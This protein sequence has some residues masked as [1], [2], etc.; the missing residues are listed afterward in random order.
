MRKSLLLLAFMMILIISGCRQTYFG[1]YTYRDFDH[2][3]HWNELTDLGH[4]RI[5]FVYYYDRDFFGTA[6]AGCKIVNESIFKFG[7]ENTLNAHLTLVNEREVQGSRPIGLR[8]APRL[9]IVESGQVTHNVLG[10]GPI[11]EWLEAIENEAFELP[12]YEPPHV[13]VYSDFEI[14]SLEKL[15]DLQDGDIVIYTY[16]EICAACQL[17]KQDVLQFIHDY[18]GRYAFYIWDML[19]VSF[20]PEYSDFPTS[21]PSVIIIESGEIIITYTGAAAV[22]DF[23]DTLID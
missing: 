20:G 9:L 19:H 18:E 22:I 11:L 1:D 15:R 23:L 12:Y 13:H 16:L 7:Q 8:T 2:L 3:D 17:I 5:D 14:F 10:A 4:N 21:V 6:C